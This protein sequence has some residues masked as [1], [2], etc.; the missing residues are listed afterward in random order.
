MLFR[1]FLRRCLSSSQQLWT[2]PQKVMLRLCRLAS[3]RV[4]NGG[5]AVFISGPIPKADWRRSQVVVILGMHRSGT[6]LLTGTLQE[7]GLV[8]GDVVTSAPHNR[9]GNRE[10]LPIRALH[11]DLL[12]SSGGSWDHPPSQVIWK[13]SHRAL[14][15]DIVVGYQHE[16]FWGF[17]DPRSLFCL[18]G[19]LE[20]LPELQ[21]V[22][23]FRHPEAVAR[24]LRAREG[25]ALADGLVLWT[26]YNQQLLYWMD[27]LDVPLLHFSSDLNAFCTD[28]VALIDRLNLPHRMSANSL[29]FPDAKLHHQSSSK[30]PLPR[31]VQDLYDQLLD[32]KFST[33]SI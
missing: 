19:W 21:P 20:V 12:H 10:A 29:Q 24:S 31:D 25:M 11:D 23:I 5:P 33:L 6:S 18:E 9:K 28:A 7:A 8:L 13:P 30:L 1:S 14:R 17:K 16:C 32:R 4:L 26:L 22:A 15:D 3:N 2:F 27:Q